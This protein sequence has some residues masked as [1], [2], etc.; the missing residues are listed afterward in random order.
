M[1]VRGGRSRD[2]RGGGVVKVFAI[3][4]A[5]VLALAGCD[6]IK[7]P[8]RGAGPPPDDPL[9]SIGL[10]AGIQ[11]MPIEGASEETSK[12]LA[13]TLAEQLGRYNIPASMALSPS[14]RYRLKGVARLDLLAAGAP[15]VTA[16]DWTLS[17]RE[18]GTVGTFRQ[19][20]PGGAWKWE[21]ADARTVRA[22][23]VAAARPI[24]TLAQG[25]PAEPVPQG[26]EEAIGSGTKQT[27]A[28]AV[29]A[30]ALG[31]GRGIYIAPVAGA[32][33]DGNDSLTRAMKAVLDLRRMKIV[34]DEAAAEFIVRAKVAISPPASGRQ[35]IAIAWAVSDD[36]GLDLGQADQ[37]NAIPAGALDGRWG[38]V[39][40]SV[41]EAAAEGVQAIIARAPLERAARGQNQAAPLALPPTHDLKQV[42]G[43][44][45]PPPS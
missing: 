7:Q 13:G 21:K 5:A 10:S 29:A 6:V 41:A 14:A 42:P 36:R 4:C 33:G 16:I 26:L 1:D 22:V 37:K 3:L 31:G 12:L 15:A 32:P 25:K 17:D 44:A 18:G 30:S 19:P 34:K 2:L 40:Y 35:T 20:V 24:A 23:G 11:V 8:F 45:P 27:G 28:T 9:M 43:R 38:T 39:A